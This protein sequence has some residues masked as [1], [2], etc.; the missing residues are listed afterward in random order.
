MTKKHLNLSLYNPDFVIF[1][2]QTS[3]RPLS[4][5]H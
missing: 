4:R 3:S 1:T 2:S 5:S